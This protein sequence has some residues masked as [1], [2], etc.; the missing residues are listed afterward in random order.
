MEALALPDSICR[1]VDVTDYEAMEVAIIEAEQL[2]GQTDLLINCAGAML[3]GSAITQNY[4]E[5]VQMIDVNVKGILTGT[6]V[7]L[8]HMVERNE[9]TIINISSIAGKKTFDNHLYI[10]VVNLLFM[11]FPRVCVKRYRETMFA[12]L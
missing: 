6:H 12:L 11:L 7:V 10:V 8:P 3:L 2:Y 5:W 4:S 9:G 1:S